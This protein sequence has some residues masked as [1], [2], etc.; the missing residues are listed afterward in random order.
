ML[1]DVHTHVGL[2]LGFQ[3]RGWWPYACTAQ[4]L[5]THMDANGIDRAVVFPFALPSAFDPYA[6]AERERVELLPQRVPFDMENTLLLQE[7]ERIDTRGRLSMLAMFDPSRMIAEQLANLESMLDR[8]AGLKTQA[9]VIESPV[10]AL[11]D[12]GAPLME[13]AEAYKMPVLMH[14]SITPADVW[15]QASD[16]L[17]VAAA[18]PKA[19]FNLA[20]SLRFHQPSLDRAKSL[21]NVWVDCSAHLGH[22][23]LAVRDHPAVATK[24]QRVDVNYADPVAVLEA[25]HDQL[26]DRYLWGSDCP[27]MSWCDSDIRMVHTYREEANVLHHLAPGTRQHMATRGPQAWLLGTSDAIA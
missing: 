24:N 7:I 17:D 22:C 1:Y 20:H 11:L 14:T 2:D 12:T 4:D 3:L 15:S 18:Y 26:G 23:G 5:L 6:F 27:F 8:I 13:F 25:I 9:T 21:D 10:R 16:C 19:R